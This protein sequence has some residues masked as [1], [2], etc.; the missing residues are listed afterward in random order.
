MAHSFG[1]MEIKESPPVRVGRISYM[2]VA[3][4]YYGLNN[5]HKPVWMDM[6]SAPPATLNAMLAAGELDVS[7]VSSAAYARHQDE[8]LLLPDFSISCFGEVMSVLLVSRRPFEDLS[9]RRVILTRESST[10]AALTRYL[11]LSKGIVPRFETGM[12][13]CARDL[14]ADA[15]AALVIGDAALREPWRDCFEYVRDLGEM[16]RERTGLAFVFALWAVRKSYAEARPDRVRAVLERFR[17]SRWEGRRNLR[18]ILPEA[19]ASLGIGPETCRR[20][21]ERLHY[22]LD[23]LQIQG[24]ERFFDGLHREGILSRPVALSFFQEPSRFFIEGHAA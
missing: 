21:Y 12:I 19:S 16:W 18:R 9:G 7:P 1:T 5:G 2:N 24:L 6:V 23:S 10:A 11:F 13:Q 8:W 15:D 22:A 20:Y 4:V 17:C 14:N 3:P